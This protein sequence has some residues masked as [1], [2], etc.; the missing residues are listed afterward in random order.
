MTV[1]NRWEVYRGES[2]NLSD[3]LFTAKQSSSIQLLKTQLNVFLASNTSENVCDFKVKG[4]S[5]KRSWTICVGESNTIIAQMKG[6]D[7]LEVTVYPNVDYVF[8]VALVVILD[9]INRERRSVE[10]F[11]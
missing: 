11:E 6:R 5:F 10:L 9:E 3:L 2:T 7:K 8:V 1:H 4:H